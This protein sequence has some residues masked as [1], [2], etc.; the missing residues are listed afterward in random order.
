MHFLAFFIS[1]F[2]RDTLFFALRWSV[3][4]LLGIHKLFFVAVFNLIEE[5]LLSDQ[6]ETSIN[7]PNI[8]MGPSDV[9][10]KRRAVNDRALISFVLIHFPY[11]LINSITF[12]TYLRNFSQEFAFAFLL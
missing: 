1:L 3:G 12:Q 9:L 6:S 11:F 2:P 10:I 5:F 7:I 4:N 8:N